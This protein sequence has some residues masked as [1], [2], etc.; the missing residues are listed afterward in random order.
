MYNDD[1]N[2][3][4][5][6]STSVKKMDFVAL[7]GKMLLVGIIENNKIDAYVRLG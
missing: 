4:N 2:I 3:K 5:C 6:V 7:P 1:I